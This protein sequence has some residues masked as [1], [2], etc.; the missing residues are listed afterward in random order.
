[1]KRLSD[2][3]LGKYELLKQL[4][5]T[6]LASVYHAR[7]TRNDTV[8]ALKVLHSYFSQ[9]AGVLDRYLQ[10]IERVQRLRHP[11]IVPVHGIDRDD[12]VTALVM[13]YVS[14][15]TLKAR[16]SRVLPL[17][18]VVA[19]LRQVAEALDYAHT[20][21]IVHRDLRPSNVFYDQVSGHVMVSDFGT[22][23]LVE[24]GHVL[25][26]S[27]VNTP[28]P[29]YGAPEHL[30]GQPPDPLNDVYALGVLTYEL[31]TGEGPFDAL[32]PYTILS[33]Q[34]T[35]TPTHPSYLDE[36]LPPAVDDVVLKALSLRPEQRHTSCKEMAESLAHAAGSQAIIREPVVTVP[37]EPQRAR[38]EAA[39]QDVAEAKELEDGRVICPQCGSG[40]SALALR[41]SS[42]WGKLVAQQVITRE[43]EQRS[44]A[45]YIGRLRLRKR[46]VWGTVSGLLAVLM[47]LWVYNLFEVRPPLPAPSSSISSQPA[48]G[49]WSMVQRDLLHTGAAPG[50]A[51]TPTGTIERIFES[52]GPLL[53]TPAVAGGQVYVATSDRRIVA[54]DEATGEVDWTYPVKGPVNSSPSIADDL[55]FVGLR[56]GTLLALNTTTGDLEWSYQTDNPIYGSATVLDG[57]LYIGSADHFLY[58]LDARTGEMRWSRE[59]GDWVTAPATITKGIVV[60]GSQDGELYMVDA[61]NGTLRYQVEI[62]SPL[63]NAVTIVDDVAYFTT[64]S[65]N[66]LAFDYAEKDVFFRKATLWWKAHLYVWSVISTPPHHAGLIWSRRLNEEVFGDVAAADGRLFVATSAGELLVL[67]TETGRTL[68]KVEDLAP[69]YSSPIVSGDTVIQAASNG[70]IYG[71][72]VATGEERWRVSV[73][74]PVR[75]SPILANGTL[76]VSTD[77]GNLY[78][79]R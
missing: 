7:D 19:I 40:N 23:T 25:L 61:S 16:K 13:D 51:F 42:C 1:M 63:D 58:A 10:E 48:A 4:G 55:V 3:L 75:A 57:T 76:Y 77:E 68:W 32:S 22:V 5:T 12:E 29:N 78:A 28:A 33:R 71:F 31:L 64:F 74:E 14:W 11:N 15:P 24:G 47:T 8:V 9:E 45:R 41:C 50:P 39:V 2:R 62:G 65:G 37:F 38:I 44:V 54:L 56:A 35:V 52:E 60:V 34:L 59:T 20:Q 30:Q 26:R 46:V 6:G 69:V 66:V 72:D 79:L 43:E 67:E 53:S 17:D 70:T 27:T 49:A 21:G 73:D 36:T 18:E